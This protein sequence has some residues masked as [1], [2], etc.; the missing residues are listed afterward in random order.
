MAAIDIGTNSTRLLVADVDGPRIV[1]VERRTDVTS[2]GQGVDAERMLADDA[3]GR[4][5]AALDGYRET[6]GE[7]GAKT[8]FAIAT[9]AM[10]DSVNGAEF[11]ADIRERLD[12]DIQT[13]S[14]DDEARLTFDGATRNRT[15][16]GKALVVDIGG[17]S[18]ELV[19]GE[20]GHEPEF[21]VSS[22]AGSIRQTERHLLADP[23]TP[24]QLASL[25][26]EVR[27]IIEANVPRPVRADLSVA[28]AVAGSATSLAAIDQ[29]LDPYVPERVHGYFVSRAAC[30]RMLALLASLPLAERRELP[31]LHPRRAPMIVAGAAILLEVIEDFGLTGVEV[32]EAD[33]L[34]GAALAAAER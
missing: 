6:I 18:T 8:T 3:M 11:V 30:E 17:G 34:H 24:E 31:G 2:L 22:E 28:I 21:H 13:I 16:G 32:S 23:P 4:V 12:I 33:I 7:L 29:R 10:R 19:V 5:F 9:S 26:V 25:R 15:H 1:E 27:D 20:I 14:G